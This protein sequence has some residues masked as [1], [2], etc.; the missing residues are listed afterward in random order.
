[1][2]ISICIPSIRQ[3]TTSQQQKKSQTQNFYLL[4]K[5]FVY[6][7]TPKDDMEIL[8]KQLKRL[9]K[10]APVYFV[11]GNHEN[12]IKFTRNKLNHKITK[13][14]IIILNDQEVHLNKIILIGRSDYTNKKPK[15]YNLTTKTYNIVLDLQTQGTKE[16]VK[17]NIDLQLSDHTHNG[18]MFPLSFSYHL[19]PDFAGNYGKETFKHHTKIISSGLVGW[20]FPIRTEGI[21]KYVVVN[22]T[23]DK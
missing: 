8:F 14:N 3:P 10:I 7:S 19:Q 15:E 9:T 5:D 21:C 2:A 16:N 1:M 11:Y 23:Q 6:E 17:N 12:K 20:G 4:G 13:N 22:I 18:Q